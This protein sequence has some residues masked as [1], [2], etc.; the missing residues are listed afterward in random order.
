MCSGVVIVLVMTS[1]WRFLP[2]ALF[3]TQR[4]RA[5]LGLQLVARLLAVLFYSAGNWE[6]SSVTSCTLLTSLMCRRLVCGMRPFRLVAPPPALGYPEL[7][8]AWV[9]VQV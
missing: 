6:W 4:K 5:V 2:P 1:P 7:W 9:G 8:G 3:P